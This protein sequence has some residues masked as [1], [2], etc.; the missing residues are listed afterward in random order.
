MCF[1]CDFFSFFLV[2]K[3][4]PELTSVVSL[5]LILCILDSAT[6][7]FD[8]QC[9]GPHLGSEPANPGLPKQRMRT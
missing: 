8:E 5:P 6:A 9:V 3:I 1:S 7:W 2:R 4:D